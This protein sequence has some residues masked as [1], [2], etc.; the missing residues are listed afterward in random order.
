MIDLN[1]TDI[2]ITP[3]NHVANMTFRRSNCSY[4]LKALI[5]NPIFNHK[6]RDSTKFANIVCN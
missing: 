5:R 3:K 6:V 4:I 1:K 2:I